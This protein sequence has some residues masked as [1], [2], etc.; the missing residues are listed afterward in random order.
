MKAEKVRME[1]V[2]M[3]SIYYEFRMGQAKCGGSRMPFHREIIVKATGG[4]PT[5]KAIIHFWK[6]FA[7]GRGTLCH[8][9]YE[10]STHILYLSAER[11]IAE[12]VTIQ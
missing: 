11:I 4:I 3:Y 1:N 12:N 10:A 9:I 5:R 8:P 7:I 2:E 6:S